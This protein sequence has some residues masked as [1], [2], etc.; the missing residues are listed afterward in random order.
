MRTACCNELGKSATR[1]DARRREREKSEAKGGEEAGGSGSASSSSSSSSSSPMSRCTANHATPSLALAPG[2]RGLI[3]S[4]TPAMARALTLLLLCAAATCVSATHFRYGSI[5]WEPTADTVVKADLQPGQIISATT[6]W[7]VNF[8]VSMAFRRTYF[9][10]AYF[11]EQWRSSDSGAW[12]RRA[13][14]VTTDFDCASQSPVEVQCFLDSNTNYAMAPPAGPYQLRFPTGMNSAGLPLV[15]AAAPI[16]CA[17]PM[18]KGVNGVASKSDIP[19]PG[20]TNAGL[21]FDGTQASYGSGTTARPVETDPVFKLGTTVSGAGEQISTCTPWNEVFGFFFGD[22]SADMTT[23][24]LDVDVVDVD[25]DD[26]M[27]GNTIYVNNNRSPL[28]KTYKGTATYTAFFTGGNRASEL[29][30]N[31]DGR[32]RLEIEVRIDNTNAARLKNRSPIATNIPILPLPYTDST[33]GHLQFQIAAYDPD[34]GDQVRY[35]FGNRLEMG[36]LLAN[37]VYEKSTAADGKIYASPTYT[38]YPDVYNDILCSTQR[39]LF[40]L[41]KATCDA[42][43]TQDPVNPASFSQRFANYQQIANTANTPHMPA[44]DNDKNFPHTP[45]TSTR[46]TIN[47]LSGTVTWKVGKDDKTATTDGFTPL[48]SGL[49][50]FVVMVEERHGDAGSTTL[51]SEDDRHADPTK[52]SLGLKVPLDFLVYLYPSMHFCNKDCAAYD[53]QGTGKIFQTFETTSGFYGDPSAATTPR[54]KAFGDPTNGLTGGFTGTCRLCGGGGVQKRYLDADNTVP[55]IDLAGYQPKDTSYCMVPSVDR[56]SAANTCCNNPGGAA[57]YGNVTSADAVPTSFPTDYTFRA[58]GC[59]GSGPASATSQ[60][61][62]PYSG[63]LDACNI[64]RQPF[65]LTEH[66]TPKGPT[67]PLEKDPLCPKANADGSPIYCPIT[68]NDEAAGLYV[69]MYKPAKVTKPKG[70]DVDFTLRAYDPDECVE[71]LIGTTGLYDNM[72]LDPHVYVN[73]RTIERNFKWPAYDGTGALTSVVNEDARPEKVFVCFYASDKYL[74]TVHPF[75]CVMIEIIEP[76][77]VKWCDDAAVGTMPATVAP[78]NSKYDVYL[79]VEFCLPLCVMKLQAQGQTA[80]LDIRKIEYESTTWPD[81]IAFPF[82]YDEVNFP[83]SGAFKHA[84]APTTDPLQKNFCFAPKIGEECTYTVCFQGIDTDSI[85]NDPA[86]IAL[87][88][89]NVRCMKLEVYNAVMEFDGAEQSIDV[90]VSKY[91]VPTNGITMAAWVHPKCDGLNVE[92]NLTAFYFGTVRNETT[93]HNYGGVDSGLEVRNSIM[94]HEDTDNMGAFFYYDYYI[95]T[96]F[97]EK[98][99]SCGVWHFVAVTI[100]EDNSAMLY[101]DGVEPAHQLDNSRD[102][103]KYAKVAFSTP[104]RPD[105]NMDGDGKGVFKVGH[106]APITPGY[107]WVGYVDEIAIYNKYMGDKE[108]QMLQYTRLIGGSYAAAATEPALVGYYTVKGV[109]PTTLVNYPLTSD[110]GEGTSLVVSVGTPSIAKVAV[111]TITPC[112]LGMQHAVGPTDG[113]CVTDVYGWNMADG[114]MPKCSFGGVEALGTHK[115][116]LIMS[117]TTPGHF[118]PRFVTVLASNDGA[119]FTS[120]T[121]ADKTVRHLFMESSLYVDGLGGGA[122]ADSVCKDLPTRAVT[123]GGWFCPKCGPPVP[124]APP[125]PPPPPSPPPPAPKPPPPTPPPPTGGRI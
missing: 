105:N 114:F 119:N 12:T 89:T 16:I 101:V 10:G 54:P 33:A 107:G 66:T 116:D 79:D 27:A 57:E 94:F 68:T 59:L 124:P 109:Q 93:P 117:C 90:D 62:V 29:L 85:S 25:F 104:S 125:P 38:W 22:N 36:G 78:P 8:Y 24:N 15:P 64:N 2:T 95:G 45:S 98:L 91:V 70:Q 121:L 40:R 102:T 123:F 9:W 87:E 31:A 97:T 77:L 1:C 18:N 111:P 100:K 55:I 11:N 112:V 122:E 53:D 7:S 103:V 61:I 86:E 4:R 43:V 35:F 52:P 92:R 49:Y 44:W 88:T 60:Q 74:V 5:K 46:L 30:N 28:K 13:S 23:T 118:S 120:T 21:V 67:P 3:T 108:I 34:V 106:L 56:N 39:G 115:T 72:Y 113:D 63:N 14:G 17:H 73:E 42:I 82:P 47:A 75:H 99:F 84:N 76:S 6:E 48:A 41:P 71:L 50:N 96:V 19:Y 110:S 58:K 81:A 65:F 26:T 80:K 37:A 69:G 51:L 83:P 20:Q 32:Y